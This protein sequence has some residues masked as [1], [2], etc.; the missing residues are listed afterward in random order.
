MSKILILT[1][2]N[3][4]INAILISHNYII[5]EFENVFHMIVLINMNNIKCFFLCIHIFTTISR[6]F[7]S[8]I[9]VKDEAY[10]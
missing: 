9:D 4:F 1:L 7:K 8:L 10:L 3:I 2:N 6:S 5:L